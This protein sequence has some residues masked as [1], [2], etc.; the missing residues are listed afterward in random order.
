MFETLSNT[1]RVPELRRRFLVTVLLLCVCRLGVYIPVPGV[2]LK[3]AQAKFARPFDA[4]GAEG[5]VMAMIDMFSGGGL[6]R[7]AIF[8]LGIMPY[9]SASIIFQLLA[10]VVPALERLQKEGEAGRRKIN[11]YTRYATVVL[12]LVQSAIMIGS[13]SAGPGGGGGVFPSTF[14]MGST[15]MAALLMTAGTLFLMWIG[16]QVDEFGIGNGISLIIMVNII[17]RMPT[18]IRYLYDKFDFTLDPEGARPLGIQ[19][20]AMLVALFVFVILSIVLITQ[21]QRRIPF[22]QAKQTR[23]RKVYG[24]VKHYLPIQ[25]NSA[26]VIPIIF[27]QSLLMFPSIFTN[28]IVRKFEAGDWDSNSGLYAVFDYVNRGLQMGSFVYEALYVA[29]IFF[30]CYFW[31]AI[32]FN[33]TEMA[34]NLRDHGSF[35]PGYRPGKRTAD[36][37]ESVMTRITLPGATFL[38]IVAIAPTIMNRALNLPWVITSFYGGTGLLIVVGVALDLVKKI[39]QQLLIRH[40]DGFTKRSRR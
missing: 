19:H 34:N 18:A 1:F 24:G 25:V 21:G 17:S 22:Q 33:P 31:T 7:A 35:I 5:G 40:Y 2:D 6:Q 8:G 11:Q 36:Y 20:M 10:S 23:G 29:M 15:L 32:Q 3:A 38:S 27:A 9:I 14:G 12:C 26:G 37:L 28:A 13:M 4:Q 30:F 39:E 16:E